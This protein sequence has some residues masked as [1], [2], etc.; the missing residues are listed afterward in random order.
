[1]KEV[2]L[3]NLCKLFSYLMKAKT[4]VKY[5][6]TFF[7]KFYVRKIY[8]YGRNS[9]FNKFILIQKHF[10]QN[11]IKCEI[12]YEIKKKKRLLLIFCLLFKTV[13]P[14]STKVFI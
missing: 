13:V 7:Y 9:V 12:L 11:C 6:A 3:K 4:C 14:Y 5:F 8:C 2:F 1:M 10:I